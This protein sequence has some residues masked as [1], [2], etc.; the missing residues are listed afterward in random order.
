LRIFVQTHD[1]QPF[2]SGNGALRPPALMARA[3]K[4]SF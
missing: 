2:P 3:D 1:V 4:H